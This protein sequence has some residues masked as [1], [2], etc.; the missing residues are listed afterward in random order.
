VKLL[1]QLTVI[2]SAAAVY[3]SSARTD[4]CGGWPERAIP[5]ATVIKTL[6]AVRTPF[7]EEI[8]PT[9]SDPFSLFFS[10]LV[11]VLFCAAVQ[12]RLSTVEYFYSLRTG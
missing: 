9:G 6:D 1:R 10:L 8:L 7:L 2:P 5:T 11:K 3:G 4:Q 12:G